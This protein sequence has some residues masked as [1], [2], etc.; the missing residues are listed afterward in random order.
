MASKKNSNILISLSLFI[1]GVLFMQMISSCGK[2]TGASPTGLNIEYRVLNLSPDMGPVNMFI[3]FNQVNAIGNPF[4][5]RADRG[6]FYLPA[7]VT[8]FQFRQATVAAT[9]VLSLNRN[10]ILQS[11]AKYTLFITGPY[12]SLTPIFT[13]D[14]DFAPAVGRGKLRFVNA[15]PSATGGLDVYA[16]GTLAFTGTTYKNI[17]KYIELPIGNYDLKINATGSATVLNDLPGVTIQDGRLYTLY[18]S[19]YTSRAD[20]AAFNAAVIINQ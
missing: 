1:A 12:N 14:T 11:G 19:G 18:A 6:Y 15:S 10:D 16:N 20:S 8:P 7:I 17:S 2:Q 4:V 5:F 9:P 13:V 3:S